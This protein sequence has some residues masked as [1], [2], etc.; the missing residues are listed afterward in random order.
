MWD[1]GSGPFH[2]AFS[3][4]LYFHAVQTQNTGVVVKAQ[5]CGGDTGCFH[6]FTTTK[7][8]SQT[9]RKTLLIL[10]CTLGSSN[11]RVQITFHIKDV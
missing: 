10:T 7:F 6:I 2:L 4:G 1:C 11:P 3:V 5:S 8:R 9:T